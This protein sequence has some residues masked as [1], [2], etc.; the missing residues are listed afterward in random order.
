MK[1]YLEVSSRNVS[2]MVVVVVMENL[3]LN[4]LG[5]GACH[6]HGIAPSMGVCY[7]SS[8]KWTRPPGIHAFLESPALNLGCL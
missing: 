4:P 3:S 1:N 2:N 7:F 8:L 5:F 6:T